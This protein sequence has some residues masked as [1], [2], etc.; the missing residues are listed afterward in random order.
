VGFIWRRGLG[1]R[2]RWTAAISGIR[3]QGHAAP[4]RLGRYGGGDGHGRCSALPPR[5]RH[6]EER[7]REREKVEER[8]G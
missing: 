1:F 3:A 6:G 2:G 7:Q 8:R 5:F 4:I